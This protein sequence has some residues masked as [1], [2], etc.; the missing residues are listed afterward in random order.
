MRRTLKAKKQKKRQGGTENGCENYQKREWNIGME[1]WA[2]CDH[3]MK[4]KA[5]M[6]GSTLQRIGINAP[7]AAASSTQV[8]NLDTTI[9]K[10]EEQIGA[11]TGTPIAKL[12]T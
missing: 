6:E 8:E 5:Q 10:N 4:G 2:P 7:K 12:S 1:G 3:V 9:Y 11:P